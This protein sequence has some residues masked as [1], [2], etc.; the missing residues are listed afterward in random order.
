VLDLGGA[1]FIRDLLR[2]DDD[3]TVRLLVQT[4]AGEANTHQQ[5]MFDDSLR[6]ALTLDEIR[7]MVENLGCDPATVKQTTDRHWTWA[8]KTLNEDAGP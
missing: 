8:A 2:P 3:A 7:A 1:L 4:Y 6:A 5:K